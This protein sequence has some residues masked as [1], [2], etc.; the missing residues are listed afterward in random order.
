MWQGLLSLTPSFATLPGWTIECSYQKK[1]VRNSALF[2]M[3]SD[4][5]SATVFSF[6]NK[7]SLATSKSSKDRAITIG[8]VSEHK[9]HRRIFCKTEERCV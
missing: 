3:N 4:K 5:T 9:R 7:T 1:R 2:P 6:Y 8:F